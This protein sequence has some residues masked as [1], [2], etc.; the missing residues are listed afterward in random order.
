MTKNPPSLGSLATP[1][2]ST[3]KKNRVAE[4]ANEVSKRT[5]IAAHHRGALMK[6]P[7][8]TI[9]AF[10][11]DEKYVVVY[12]DGG[13]VVISDS[14]KTLE[15]D[16]A[17]TFLRIHRNALVAKIRIKS[18]KDNLIKLTDSDLELTVSRRHLS[19][20]R[21]FIRTGNHEK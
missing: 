11:A 18:M 16:I 13:E 21:R 8:E 12:H 3:T 17:D 15:T 2:P 10:V 5:H 14:L 9:Q 1:R 20:V 7:L 4:P 6:I 19:T